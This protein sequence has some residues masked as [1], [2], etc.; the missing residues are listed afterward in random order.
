MPKRH[1]ILCVDDEPQILEGLRPTLSK[2]YLVKT[3]ASGSAALG[4]LRTTPTITVIISDMR[5]PSM[6]GAQFLSASRQIVP[7]ARR[8]LL[9]G[10]ADVATALA[11]VNEGG[12][13]RLLTKP[14]PVAE[15]IEAIDEAIADC[16]AEARERAK[17]RRIAERDVL[18]RDALTGL[19]SRN[20]LI[21]RL[22]SYKGRRRTGEWPTE[23]LFCI[24]IANVDELADGYESATTDQAMHVVVAR[25]REIFDPVECLARY[26]LNTFVA[27]MNLE[28]SSD[29]A[30]E[31]LAQR[32][33]RALDHP[34]AVEGTV[35]QYRAR[36]GIARTSIDRDAPRVVLRYA[37][38]AAREAS[39]AGR[40]SICFFS[41]GLRDRDELRGETIR[42]LRIA[43]AQEQLQLHYQ[44]IIDIEHN[45]VY[46]IEA[47]ARWEHSKLGVISPGTFIPLAEKSGLMVPLGEWVLDRACAEAPTSGGIFRRVSVNVSMTQILHD[48][49]IFAVSHAI[50][51]SGIEPAAL[52]LE[53][54]ESAFAEDLE[55]VCAV[56]SE[57]RRLGISVAIDDFGAG[58]SS[59]AYLSRLPVDSV[60]I[61]AVFVRD[62]SRGG[63]AIIGAAL[64]V[65]QKLQ[66]EAVIE[67]VET[68]DSL[69][70]V[71]RLGATKVQGYLFARPMPATL[72]RSWH[73]EFVAHELAV[74]T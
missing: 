6:N 52:V 62:F 8:I 29:A 16:D 42:A 33:V 50:E 63:E 37:E 69:D 25:L 73:S 36:V 15:V 9:T 12:I 31:Q 43:I 64:A 14:C 44:P 11:A 53:V 24:E 55:K 17:L 57:V 26:K 28:D 74:A 22:D 58:Y 45:R 38:L 41:Q 10:H 18:G 61:D 48:R 70:Q 2:K 23:V 60:K 54:T 51:R 71:R 39:R 47:L 1:V 49:F 30:A 67:G 5:M 32:V 35:L 19:A 68:A 46:S 40:G 20:S 3:A 4:I 7:N 13:C 34:I 66:I 65:A 72:L 27:V 59:L 56:L 21:E